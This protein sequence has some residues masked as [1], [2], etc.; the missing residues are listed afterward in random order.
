MA[1]LAFV[2]RPALSNGHAMAFISEINKADMVVNIIIQLLCGL[3]LY[4]SMMKLMVMVVLGH[5][6]RTMC[7]Q[8]VSFGNVLCIS[9]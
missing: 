9:F 4:H 8:G 6:Y 7:F 3:L 2:F 1:V 5:Q